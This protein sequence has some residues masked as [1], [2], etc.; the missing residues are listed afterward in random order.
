MYKIL[1]IFDNRKIYFL[2]LL[3]FFKRIDEKFKLSWLFKV[4]SGNKIISITIYILEL[5]GI[6][7]INEC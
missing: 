7:T 4:N 3:D 2:F 6:F 1:I 5:P